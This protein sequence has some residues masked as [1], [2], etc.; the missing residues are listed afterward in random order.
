MRSDGR[1][2]AFEVGL[3]VPR[4]NGKGAILE[5]L[6]LAGLFLW[7]EMLILHSAHEFKTARE[8]F[9]RLGARIAANPWLAGRVLREWRSHGDE[10][11]ELKS[12]ARL[13]FV[14]RTG[15]SGRGFSADRVVLDEAFKLDDTAMGALLPTLSARPNPQIWYTSSAPKVDSSQLH[16]VRARGV[17]GGDPGALLLRVVGTGDGRVG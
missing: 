1:W 11:F 16:S 5:A 17:A 9:L 12:G 4:Q 2:S 15:G 10:G 13:R 3:V 6:E 7:D 8:G 14:A